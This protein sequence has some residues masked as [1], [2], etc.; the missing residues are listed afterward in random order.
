MS[1][2]RRCWI[3]YKPI[4]MDIFFN[5]LSVVTKNDGSVTLDS[6]V[7]AF[8]LLVRKCYQELRFEKVRYPLELQKVY[9]EEGMTLYQY[10]Q[11]NGRDNDMI[12]VL[13]SS[14]YPYI[15][16]DDTKGDEFIECRYEVE[17]DGVKTESNGFACACLHDSFCVGLPS[18]RFPSIANPVYTVYITHPNDE[19]PKEKSCYNLSNEND[20]LT[21]EFQTWAVANGLKIIA[22]TPRPATAKGIIN[23]GTRGHHGTDELKEFAKVIL[24]DKYVLNVVHS[25]PNHP[26]TTFFHGAIPQNGRMVINITLYKTP[27]GYSMAVETTAKDEFEAEWIAKRLDEMY[28][29]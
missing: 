12:L 26:S 4:V 20:V 5:E 6:R 17:I 19:Q 18:T 10:C 27:S 3:W 16:D 21:E 7:K 2:Q 29:K 24:N 23:L 14:R 15:A 13:S 22:P 25:L 9:I 1:G 8:A 11:Q 28:Y